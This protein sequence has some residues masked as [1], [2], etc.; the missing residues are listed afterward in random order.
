MG[1]HSAIAQYKQMVINYIVLVGGLDFHGKNF[2][3][4]QQRLLIQMSTSAFSGLCSTW[5]V[6][7]IILRTTLRILQLV[8][9]ILEVL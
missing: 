3:S 9:H 8:T 7:P 2:K 1:A 4:S 5:N 6:K